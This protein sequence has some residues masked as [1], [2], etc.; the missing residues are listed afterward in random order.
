[1]IVDCHAETA[2]LALT[3][4]EVNFPNP[5]EDQP[6]WLAL[7]QGVYNSQYP[8]WDNNSCD[9]GLR[10]QKFSFNNGGSNLSY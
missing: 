4:A 7:A 9:G 5:P 3:A 8:L 1:M 2:T 10:W 6:S